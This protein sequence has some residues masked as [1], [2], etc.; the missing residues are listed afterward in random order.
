MSRVHEPGDGFV[1][2][3][4]DARPDHGGSGLRNFL[5]HDLNI[6][7]ATGMHPKSFEEH[8]PPFLTAKTAEKTKK[9]SGKLC[10]LC[11]PGGDRKRST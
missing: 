7:I 10:A 5:A 9:N 4:F 6:R 8:G 2:E 1:R 3:A 11:V